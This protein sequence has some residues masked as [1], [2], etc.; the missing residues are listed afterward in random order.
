MTAQTRL[1]GARP[2]DRVPGVAT[3]PVWRHVGKERRR[4]IGPFGGGGLA[5]LHLVVGG[6]VVVDAGEAGLGLPEERGQPLEVV[7]LPLL[8][9]VVVA[10]GAVEAYAEEGAGDAAG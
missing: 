2:R 8:E 10:L 7:L 3:P 4:R 6:R 9:G 5:V 1:T